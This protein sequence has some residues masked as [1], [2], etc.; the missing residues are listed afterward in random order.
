MTKEKIEIDMAHEK[1]EIISIKIIK[2]ISEIFLL[3][4]ESIQSFDY[5][6][7]DK[8]LKS[9]IFIAASRFICKFNDYA[10][11][12]VIFDFSYLNQMA[13]FLCKARNQEKNNA[14]NKDLN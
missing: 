12:E 1:A 6:I 10:E 11:D 2:S 5:D 14:T 8:I 9:C 4:R 13:I 3:E 7:Q